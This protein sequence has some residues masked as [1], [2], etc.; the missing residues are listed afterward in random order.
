MTR[1]WCLKALLLSCAALWLGLQ[2]LLLHRF[3]HLTAVAVAPRLDTPQTA[4][5]LDIMLSKY[6][7]TQFDRIKTTVPDDDRVLAFLHIGK[8]AGS[9]ISV[10][11]RNGCHEC[12]MQSCSGRVDGWIVNETIA[13]QRI[14]SYYHMEYIPQDK[15]N[16]ITTIITAVRNPITRFVSAFAYEHPFNSNSANVELRINTSHGKLKTEQFTCFPKLHYLVNAAAGKARIHYNKAHLAAMRELSKNARTRKAVG[17][18]HSR[19][20]RVHEKDIIQP[21]DCTELAKLTFSVNK[22]STEIKQSVLDGSHPFL[23]HM[24]FDYR[25]YYQSMPPEKELLVLRQENLWND[26][27]DL[28]I[29]LGKVNPKYHNWPAVP[30][31]QGVERNVSH[32]YEFQE[33]W[34]LH[35]R[36]DQ[37]WLCHLLRDEIRTYLMI[38]MRAVNLNEDDLL[39]AVNDVES[40]CDS[41]D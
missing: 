23:N 8:T 13:S 26:W 30:P 36:Q 16:E 25:Q 10:N 11:I 40:T 12:C 31:F 37:H 29:L 35:D 15:L 6:N 4:N 17:K 14:R 9:T 22:I 5:K 2:L 28:N 24:T 41:L 7:L 1:W 3:S 18:F 33:R 19:P 38:I 21:I 39:R 27:N 20:K 34:K 32:Q